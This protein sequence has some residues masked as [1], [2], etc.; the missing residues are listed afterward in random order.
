[1]IDK[2]AKIYIAGHTG[3][4]GSSI[5]RKYKKEGYSSLLYKTRKEL[6]LFNQ[7]QVE[8]FF[9]KERPEYVI[10]SAARVGGIKAN[11]TYSADFLYENLQ[12][13]NNII[14]SAQK[15]NV[16]KLLFL[17]SSCIYPR[18]CPQPMKEEY[19]MTGKVEPTNEGYAIAK[20]AG[21]ELC[22]KIF[23]Q[24]KKT[25]ISCMP[26]NI[27]GE[28]DHYQEDSS[29]VIPGLLNRFYNA[30]I[31]NIPEVKIWG[32]GNNRREFLYV[33]DLAD[34][35]FWIMNNYE[36]SPFLNVGTGEDISIKELVRYIQELIDYKGEIIFDL[37][38]PDGMPRKLMDVSKIQDLG[39]KH[40]I[41][42]QE[43]LEKAYK[44]FL[45]KKSI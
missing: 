8:Q 18:D 7:V 23:Q 37:T 17:G 11:M 43:G 27:Y 9:L 31:N 38:K 3:M 28:N 2:K 35:V 39:W 5:L 32:S 34:A 14:W 19:F 22:E 15:Y 25:F 40:K 42:L 29:H 21:V 12:I 13:Q 4:V 41:S 16:K 24:Y 6:D 36:S 20:I 33:D 10:L 44:D 45:S 1:M 26:T 30:K